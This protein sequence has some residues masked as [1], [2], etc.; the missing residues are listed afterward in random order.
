MERKA[1][2]ELR[3]LVSHYGERCVLKHINLTVYESEVMVIMGGSGSGKSTLLYHMLALTPPT[4]GV[5]K[6]LGKDV[7]RL[8]EHEMLQLRTG[9]G[10]AFQGGALFSSRTVLE[11]VMLPLEERT[12]LGRETMEIMARMKLD[13][14]NLSGF[15]HFFPEQLSGGMVKRAALARA[16]VLDPKVLFLD[17]PSAGLDPVVS[18]EL[19]AMLLR[20]RDAL[21]V[22]I[23]VVTHELESMRSLAD[24]VAVL[25]EGELLQVGTL[26]D[27][28]ASDRP[29]V[30]N[31]LNR[32]P[33]DAELD[34]D[35]YLRRLAGRGESQ[36][37]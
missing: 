32:R 3:D 5:I 28:E 21:D 16:L 7:Q 31:L 36:S 11:N 9:I 33:R 30:Q 34:P 20:L 1:V 29:Q 6:L 15:E 18:A 23:V 4:S 27:I 13:L 10:V 12:D 35:E 8:G 14:V 24:R 2:I 22:A 26:V 17:E 25:H 37:Y 19:D